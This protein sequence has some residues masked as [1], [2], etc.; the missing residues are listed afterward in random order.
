MNERVWSM[1]KAHDTDQSQ[2]YL[3]PHDVNEHHVKYEHLG[4]WGR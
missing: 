4:F 3:Q 2:N 1:N